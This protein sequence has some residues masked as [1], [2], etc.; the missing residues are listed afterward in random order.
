MKEKVMKKVNNFGKI[1]LIIGHVCRVLT[2]L[3]A[4]CVILFS[5]VMVT[6]SGKFVDV[7]YYTG[8][9]WS[10]NL[11]GFSEEDRANV[12]DEFLETVEEEQAGQ[13]RI[14][15]TDFSAASGQ[16]NFKM[17]DEEMDV[18]NAEYDEETDS[19]R[20]DTRTKDISI[21]TPVKMIVLSIC[22]ILCAVAE[23]VTFTFLI[24][25]C[26]EFKTCETPFTQSIVDRM[27]KVA[28]SLI[29][30]CI[31]YPLMDASVEML[32]TNTFAFSLNLGLIFVV[33]AIISLT[34]MFRYGVMLQQESDETL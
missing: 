31:T 25:L 21:T 13:I 15:N 3:A 4:I 12:V 24:Q 14:Q 29:P 5:V 17:Q 33:F 30:W 6:L 8:V 23:F 34:Y 32:A 26:R 10:M 19:I 16:L 20:V 9:K 2:V 18:I 28:Y 1:G 7:A 27:K 11:S 22:V